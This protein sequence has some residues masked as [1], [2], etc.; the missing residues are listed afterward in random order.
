MSL[1]DIGSSIKEKLEKIT[2]ISDI[3]NYNKVTILIENQISP[4][5]NRMNCIQGMLSQY[6]IMKNINNIHFISA[7]NKLKMFFEKKKTTYAERKKDSVDVTNKL[8]Y[9]NNDTDNNKKLIIEMFHKNKKKDDL[10]DCFLQAIWYIYNNK[11]E[12]LI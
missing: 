4:I 10:S 12:T 1:I 3:K 2:E 7:S 8:L 11:P 6:F 9:K 5:A